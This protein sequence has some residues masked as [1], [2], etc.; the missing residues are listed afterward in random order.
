MAGASNNTKKKE[1]AER[2]LTTGSLNIE[3]GKNLSRKTLHQE[4]NIIVGKNPNK[5]LV[6]VVGRSHRSF[7]I[8][9]VVR[10]PAFLDV[11][12]KPLVQIAIELAF[13]NSGLIVQLNLLHQ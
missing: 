9:L 10:C 5:L 1:T 12:L 3:S 4:R 7:A 6:K 8:S 13:H 11:F 2:R